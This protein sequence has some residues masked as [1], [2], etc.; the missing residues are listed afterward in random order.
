MT[1]FLI[2]RL[3]CPVADQRRC[4]MNPMCIGL[5]NWVDIGS[6]EGPNWGRWKSLGNFSRL[7]DCIKMPLKVGCGG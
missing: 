2:I 1:D 6:Q 7:T 5:R 3:H 4:R